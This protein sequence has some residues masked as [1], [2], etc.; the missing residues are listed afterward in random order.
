MF[1]LIRSCRNMNMAGV[2]NIDLMRVFFSGNAASAAVVQLW[3]LKARLHIG[4]TYIKEDGG[5]SSWAWFYTPLLYEKSICTVE[6]TCSCEFLC[7]LLIW[8]L[9]MCLSMKWASHLDPRPSCVLLLQRAES[10]DCHLRSER[11]EL[12]SENWRVKGCSAWSF[13]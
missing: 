5:N 12:D 4:F 9:Q 2:K 3:L 11:V 13:M 6:A 1:I 8:E 10:L 7:H